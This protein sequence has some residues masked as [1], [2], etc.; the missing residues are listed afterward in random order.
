M[1]FL[2]TFDESEGCYRWPALTGFIPSLATCQCISIVCII[3][4]F[5]YLTNKFFFTENTWLTTDINF[6]GSYDVYIICSIIL[7]L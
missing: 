4:L 6:A 7:A 5:V 2:I 1:T 3:L